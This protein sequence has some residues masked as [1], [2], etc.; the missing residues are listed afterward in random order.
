MRCILLNFIISVF[1]PVLLFPNNINEN[2]SG[3]VDLAPSQQHTPGFSH[4]KN[5]YFRFAKELATKH[6]D[7][8]KTIIL[9][10]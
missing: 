5:K 9:Q 4:D 2:F 6:K 1:F 3:F 8:L 10:T 7:M